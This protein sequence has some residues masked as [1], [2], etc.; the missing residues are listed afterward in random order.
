MQLSLAV[1]GLENAVET[2]LRVAGPEVADA[3]AQLMAALQPAIRQ[4]LMDVVA[5]AA[6]EISSQLATQNVDIRLVDGDPE[7]AVVDDPTGMPAPPPSDGDIDEARIT[8]R[9]PGYLKDLVADA[10]S[11]SGDSVNTFVIDTLKSQTRTTKGGAT[12]HR[13][14]IEL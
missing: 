4:T 14:T 7:L 1:A 8:I 9:L 3:G 12:R 11:T 6:T 5:M 10:A 13:A 2:Q